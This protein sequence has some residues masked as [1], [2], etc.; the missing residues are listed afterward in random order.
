MTIGFAQHS[1]A[2]SEIFN[3]I[4]LAFTIGYLVGSVATTVKHTF[5][6]VATEHLEWSVLEKLFVAFLAF[7]HWVKSLHLIDPIYYTGKTSFVKKF[8]HLTF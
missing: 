4:P 8:F 7:S 5:A 3:S 1:T 2:I 6:L